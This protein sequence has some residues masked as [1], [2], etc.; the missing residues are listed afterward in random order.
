MS[1]YVW[2][3]SINGKVADEIVVANSYSVDPHGSL[4]FWA[5]LGEGGQIQSHIFANGRWQSVRLH[6][7]ELI[8]FDGILGN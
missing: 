6:R 3:V 4:T 2:R 7:P 8:A 1:N 5:E